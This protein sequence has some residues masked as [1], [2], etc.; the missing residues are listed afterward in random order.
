MLSG[1]LASSLTGRYRA[2]ELLPL[3]FREFLK[4]PHYKSHSPSADETQF[5]F[6]L[7][8]E[9][10][11]RGGFPEVALG[12]EDPSNYLSA[13]VDSTIL[14]DIVQRFKLRNPHA[15]ASL[16]GLMMEE[17]SARFSANNLHKSLSEPKL[18][19]TSILKYL[20]MAKDAYLF[21]ELQPFFAKPRM[22]LK[23]DRKLYLVDHAL[24]RIRTIGISEKR[25]AIL[26]NL[27]FIELVRRGSIPN[28]KLFYFQTPRGA[29]VDFLVRHSRHEVELIQV[30]Y[31]IGAMKTLEREVNALTEAARMTGAR[32]L[33][34]ITYNEKRK[35]THDTFEIEVIPAWEWLLKT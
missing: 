26:E 11:Q 34:V 33:S 24:A 6:E 18:S 27:I 4:H 13:L 22:R 28:D 25:G 23:A 7:F 20:S 3:S 1:E 21:F 2:F 5:T 8:Q 17:P 9:Y 15:V 29:E 12:K 32:K 30:S 19:V 35:I 16:L 10:W 14:R 31:E